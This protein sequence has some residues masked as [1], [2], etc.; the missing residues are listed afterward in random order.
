LFI[1]RASANAAPPENYSKSP[2]QKILPQDLIHSL[3]QA[4]R[5]GPV[6][7]EE[8]LDLDHVLERPVGAEQNAVLAH[9]VRRVT[10]LRGG[11]LQGLPVPDHFEAAEQAH[12]AYIATMACFPIG[13]RR[14][15]GCRRRC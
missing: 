13:P 8:W 3:R 6:E 14:I 9:A 2:A 4:V 5:V 1:A 15:P 11:R 12:A 7:A 10:R